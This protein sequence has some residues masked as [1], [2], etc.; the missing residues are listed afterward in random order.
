MEIDYNSL[1]FIDFPVFVLPSD[2]I[3]AQDGLIYCDN[4]IIDD[5]NQIGD[6]IGKR[7]LQTPHDIII[8]KKCY[9]DLQ[10]FLQAKEKHYIDNLGKVFSYKKTLFT[11]VV[12]HKI[13]KVVDKGIISVIKAEGVSFP[14]VVKRPPSPNM[15]WIAMLYWKSRP[16]LPYS[17]SEI[18]CAS[19]RR[20][21]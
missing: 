9:E 11:K 16:W 19:T 15:E 17:Y 18:H 1:E 21:I 4:G 10:S 7:R 3:H 2:N 5:R 20:K 14:I 12:Y 8:L 13:E 6:T